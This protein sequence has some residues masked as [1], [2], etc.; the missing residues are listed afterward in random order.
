[1][2]LKILLAVA[3][4]LACTLP[5]A[6]L[7]ATLKVCPEGCTYTSIQAAIDSSKIQDT[8]KIGPGTYTETLR[9]AAPVSAKILTLRGAGASRT[10]VN[11]N[12]Q[13]C[14]LEI[15]LG[16]TVDIRG[17]TFTNGRCDPAGGILSD[18]SL[19]LTNVT[20]RQNEGGTAGG[21]A[22]DIDG[23]LTMVR[24]TVI[25][26]KNANPTGGL[27]G[28]IF[29]LGA[30]VL[31][32][33]TVDGNSATLNGGGIENR[34]QLVVTRCTITNN[35]TTGIGGGIESHGNGLNIPATVTVKN[36]FIGNNAAFGGGGIYITDATLSMTGTP[37]RGNTAST[38][39]AMINS[40]SGNS[41]LTNCPITGNTVTVDGGG[42]ANDRGNLT[43]VN[44]PIKNNTAAA[45]GSSGGS[46]GGG[47]AVFGG[48]AQ[49]TR[50]PVQ[51]NSVSG[52]IGGLGGGIVITDNGEL[53]LTKSSVTKNTASTSGGGI[54]LFT[55]TVD[56]QS[57]EVRNNEP[58]NCVNVPGC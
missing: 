37:L 51:N 56:F 33:T 9:I 11:A 42:I 28:G 41:T 13:D 48:T 52:Q 21:I 10:I 1:M 49:L 6:I 44:S 4:A 12:Q 23:T 30:A 8:I 20:V 24:G 29:T 31:T 58:D 43:L 50:S 17:M 54:Y 22:N 39:G 35:S 18:G 19:T 38:G 2:R 40:L 46:K 47:L 7:A 34:G 14:V 26:N 5:S 53:T 3:G 16:Y 25:D 36:S 15:D 27:G 45:S 55:G 57:S 32:D